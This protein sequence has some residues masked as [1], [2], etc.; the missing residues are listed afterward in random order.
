MGDSSSDGS[1]L[2]R[3][4][5]GRLELFKVKDAFSPLPKS[6]KQKRPLLH[7]TAKQPERALKS[8]TNREKTKNRNIQKQSVSDLQKRETLKIQSREIT[9]KDTLDTA[10]TK[11]KVPREKPSSQSKAKAKAQ[12]ALQ[13]ELLER[14]DRASILPLLKTSTSGFPEK[15]RALVWTKLLQLPRNKKQHKKLLQANPSLSSLQAVLGACWPELQALPS[16]P[17][18]IK[19]LSE[20][21]TGHPT[22]GFECAAVLLK[23][24]L[25]VGLSVS[26]AMPEEVFQVN[27]FYNLHLKATFN[28]TLFLLP[29][30]LLFHYHAV[31]EKYPNQ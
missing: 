2:A 5:S 24:Y 7:P 13:A 15:S 10:P 9:N 19:P 8:D 6:E 27:P 31:S 23:D 16:L 12:E 26:S 22:T 18:L 11:L 17:L 4:S 25:L 20:L 1:L 29:L 21:F 28:A 3:I 30:S 14:V